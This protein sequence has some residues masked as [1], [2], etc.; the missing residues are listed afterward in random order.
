[1]TF[2]FLQTCFGCM[3]APVSKVATEM[4]DA[5]SDLIGFIKCSNLECQEPGVNKSHVTRG[6]ASKLWTV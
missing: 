2:H 1:M 3:P 4:L 6:P 5:S